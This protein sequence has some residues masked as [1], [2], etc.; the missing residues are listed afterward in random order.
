[1]SA[2]RIAVQSRRSRRLSTAPIALHNGSARDWDRCEYCVSLGGISKPNGGID[3][4]M[5]ALVV[6]QFIQ[7]DR[8]AN[9]PTSRLMFAWPIAMPTLVRVKFFITDSDHTSNRPDI[10]GLI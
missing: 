2:V 5:H 9:S 7:I 4:P 8:S 6:S 3:G 10:Y 1:M